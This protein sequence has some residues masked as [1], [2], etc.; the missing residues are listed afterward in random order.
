MSLAYVNH[1]YW[2]FSTAYEIYTRSVSGNRNS[3]QI[4]YV[5]LYNGGTSTHDTHPQWLWHCTKCIFYH[6]V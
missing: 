1:A 3:L 6:L 5:M 4:S 2:W